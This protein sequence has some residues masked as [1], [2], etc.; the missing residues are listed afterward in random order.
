M[1]RKPD[2]AS[3][4]SAGDLSATADISTILADQSPLNLASMTQ[5][6]DPQGLQLAVDAIPIPTVS[7]GVLSDGYQVHDL[8]IVKRQSKSVFSEPAVTWGLT[9]LAG[10]V[11]LRYHPKRPGL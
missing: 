1:S 9:F 4:G 5:N 2:E 7:T 11:A 8:T 3:N 10:F 6:T